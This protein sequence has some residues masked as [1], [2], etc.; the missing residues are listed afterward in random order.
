MLHMSIVCYTCPVRHA[1]A[2]L[3]DSTD[4]YSGYILLTLFLELE[5]CTDVQDLVGLC[6]TGEGDTLN[7]QGQHGPGG[8]GPKCVRV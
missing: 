4:P 2:A 3:S 1:I 6:L 7:E 8:R 5:A